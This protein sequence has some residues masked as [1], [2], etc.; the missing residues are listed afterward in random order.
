LCQQRR[1]IGNIVGG[2]HRSMRRSYW[3]QSSSHQDHAIGF[4]LA[5]SDWRCSEVSVQMRS[6]PKILSQD[7]GPSTT[8]T[9]N[10][11]VLALIAMGHRYRRKVDSC[12]RQLYLRGG[13]GRILHKMNRSET[14]HQCELRF[15]QEILLAKHHLSLWHP[16]A[17]NSR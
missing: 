7:E 8:R 13:R 3:S 15:N 10:S 14:T 2:P 4:L 1:R 9:T 12:A 6:V 17:H 5:S 16:Q 11:P